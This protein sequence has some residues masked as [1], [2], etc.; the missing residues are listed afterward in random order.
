[1]VVLLVDKALRSSSITEIRNRGKG[2]KLELSSEGK[3][4]EKHIQVLP[5]LQKVR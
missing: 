1:M 5:C 4:I 3:K 2:S